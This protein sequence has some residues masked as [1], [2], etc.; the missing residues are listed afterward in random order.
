MADVKNDKFLIGNATVMIAPVSANVFALNPAQHSV[1]M[2]KAVTITEE[3]DQ[4]M[5]KNGVTQSTVDT[6]KSNVTM[7]T[8]FEGYEFSAS[9]LQYAL[10]LH[11][12]TVK[13]LRGKLDANVA[14]GGTEL[15]ISSYPLPNDLNSGIDEAGD[16]PSGATLLLQKA[17]EP[18]NVYPCTATANASGAGPL[19]VS[20]EALPDGVSFSA[21]DTLWVMNQVEAGRTGQDEYFCV[22]IVGTL[23]AEDE[24]LAIIMPKVKISKGFNLSFSETDY[25]N[26][27][28]ELMPLVMTL[29]E[30]E[31]RPELEGFQRFSTKAIVGG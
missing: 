27:P 18:D 26:L 29:S 5:L 19:T 31:S 30:V 21:G 1:G 3:S 25:S 4:I 28:F 17:N 8:T 20:I 23:S 2:V 7:N 6:Q 22:K 16:I 12:D 11:G 13:R 14:S 15:T 24:P 10:G 9:N